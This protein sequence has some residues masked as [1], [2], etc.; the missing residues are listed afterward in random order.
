[1]D[2]KVQKSGIETLRREQTQYDFYNVTIYITATGQSVWGVFAR[3]T[4]PK[5]TQFGP[6]KGVLLKDSCNAVCS[7]E[8]G[9]QQV[10]LLVESDAGE[11]HSLDVFDE[12][13]S[14]WM[15]FVRGAETLKE[16]NLILNQQGSSLYFT[17]MRV[18]HPREELRVWYSSSYASK[19]GLALLDN[20]K[21]NAADMESTWPCFECNDIFFTSKDLQ[22]HLNIHD[23]EKVGLIRL[24]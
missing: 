11:I 19:R 12:N 21:K 3:K 10:R 20:G 22:R 17:T 24:N 18:I 16:Q 13:L 4:I 15:R 23:T 6:M 14:N 5:R 2:V 8:V 1:M 9:S 7:E